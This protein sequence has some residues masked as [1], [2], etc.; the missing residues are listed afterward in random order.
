VVIDGIANG[1]VL[2]GHEG[3]AEI[4]QVVRAQLDSLW[5]ADAD[6]EAVLTSV[7]DRIAPL[8]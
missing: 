1:E 2:P 5:L 3:F 8:L 6:V 4:Q 7:C